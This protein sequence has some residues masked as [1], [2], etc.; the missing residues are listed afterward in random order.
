MTIP[1]SETAKYYHD[2][3]FYWLLTDKHIIQFADDFHQKWKP[4]SEVYGAK[5]RQLLSSKEIP[6]HLGKYAWRIMKQG[7]KDVEPIEK[8]A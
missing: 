6:Y 1:F 7:I 3:I 8:A 5:R 2:G 4:G